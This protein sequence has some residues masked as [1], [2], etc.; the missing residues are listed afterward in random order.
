MKAFHRSQEARSL[1]RI[2]LHRLPRLALFFM[3]AL[4]LG[5][6]ASAETLRVTAWHMAVPAGAPVQREAAGTSDS[7]VGDAAVALKK[8]DPDVILLEEVRDW[9]MC[10]KL[11][12]ALRPADY[13]VLV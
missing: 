6:P 8:L 12:E 13:N 5:L 4:R 1:K 9:Q 3:V 2:S 10:A 7:D 11:I